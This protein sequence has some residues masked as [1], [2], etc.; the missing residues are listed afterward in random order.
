V[1]LTGLSACVLFLCCVCFHGWTGLCVC[2][3]VQQSALI[4]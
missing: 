3:S 1:T 4:F 2:L